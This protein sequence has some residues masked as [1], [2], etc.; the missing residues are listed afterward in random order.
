MIKKRANRR[1]L[2]RQAAIK[3]RKLHVKQVHDNDPNQVDCICEL[4]NTYFAKRSISCNCRKRKKG[5]PRSSNGLCWLGCRYTLYHRRRQVLA[6]KRAVRLGFQLDG[7]YIASLTKPVPIGCW[8]PK[9]LIESSF[10]QSM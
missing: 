2:T 3:R 7:D 4:S 6:L 1:Y 10:Y 9:R 5:A 8:S